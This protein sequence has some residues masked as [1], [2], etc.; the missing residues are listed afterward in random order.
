MKEFKGNCLRY[1]GPVIGRIKRN[2]RLSPGSEAVLVLSEPYD[3]ISLRL[4]LP[5]WPIKNLVGVLIDAEGLSQAH[6]SIPTVV[7][8]SR[9][10]LEQLD[11][12]DVILIE[13]NGKVVVLYQINSDHNSICITKKCNAACV[14]CPQPPVNVDN[15]LDSILKLIQLMDSRHTKCL[16]ITG[17]EPTLKETH[18]VH[19]IKACRKS[20][21]STQLVLLTNG[22]KLSDLELAK[23]IVSA[24]NGL[25][26]F[27]IPLY[28]DNDISHDAIMGVKGCFYQTIEGIHNLALLKQPLG[29]RIVLHKMTV[30]RLPN[31]A[32][33]TYRN[34]PFVRQVAFMGMETIGLAHTNLDKLWIEPVD[35]LEHLSRA[36]RHLSR[37]MM[38]VSIYN[39]QLC[40]LPPDL[41]QFARRSISTWKEHYLEMCDE[42]AAK[43]FCCGFFSTGT[44]NS[45]FVHPLSD[46]EI[47]SYFSW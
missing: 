19:V 1:G 21:P 9:D 2:P 42:C 22:K 24:A 13:P 29:L 16:A 10:C 31:Y 43:K 23:R 33:F 47:P 3:S 6:S 25:I 15:D 40:L 11:D 46:H 4:S 18:L 44:R 27:E 5:F 32:E 14:M 28:S 26:R 36:V 30:E 7:S 45:D 20:L 34:L 35:Y 37:R 8:F 12:G 17:G 38:G 39:H 41:W